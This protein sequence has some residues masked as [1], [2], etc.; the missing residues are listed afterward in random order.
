MRPTQA[1]PSLDFLFTVFIY[2]LLFQ[3][4]ASAVVIE[5]GDVARFDFNLAGQQPPPPYQNILFDLW[6]SEDDFGPGE[7]FSL[8]AFDNSGT[9]LSNAITIGPFPTASGGALES[10][11]G[12]A[13]GSFFG[14]L[15]G[16]AGY[17]LMTDIVGRFNLDS[18]RVWAGN[19]NYP[20]GQAA[21]G[22]VATAITVTHVPEPAT[23]ALLGIGLAGLA[24]GR[25]R[26]GR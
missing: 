24:S 12:G 3:Q 11:F 4:P 15:A 17:L 23:L 8:Q 21:T 7:A 14:V 26:G 6:F 9:A 22:K 13:G 10:S 16:P 20:P 2:L 25:R 5:S 1:T 19:L 18:L